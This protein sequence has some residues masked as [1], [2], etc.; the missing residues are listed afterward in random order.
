MTQLSIKLLTC[1]LLAQTPT[2]L[3][4]DQSRNAVT[5]LVE[6]KPSS[7]SVLC[8]TSEN[9]TYSTACSSQLAV[10][11]TTYLVEPPTGPGS[12]QNERNGAMAFDSSG[13]MYTCDVMPYAETTNRIRRWKRSS[14]TMTE[15]W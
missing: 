9:D 15:L 4:F 11:P 6:L 1:L 10:D 5:L 2:R 12:C 3:T 14:V 13:L 8:V 7:A